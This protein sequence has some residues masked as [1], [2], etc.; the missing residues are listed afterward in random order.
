MYIGFM[1]LLSIIAL[2]GLGFWIVALVDALKRPVSEWEMANQSQIVWIVV[3]LFAN[4]IGALVYW[5]V[6]RPQL[7][8]QSSAIT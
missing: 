1:G 7:E 8:S 2:I 3:I 5:V 6:A 4:L